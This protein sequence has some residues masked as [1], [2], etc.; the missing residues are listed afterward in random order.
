MVYKGKC[1][2]VDD[3]TT[4]KSYLVSEG[5]DRLKKYSS[6]VSFRVKLLIMKLSQPER[7]IKWKQYFLYNQKTE[8]KGQ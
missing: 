5:D 4:Q 3:T 6:S 7:L 2:S 1:E 8:M